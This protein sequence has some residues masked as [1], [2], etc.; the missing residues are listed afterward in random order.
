M[1]YTTADGCPSGVNQ[2][3]IEFL[4]RELGIPRDHTRLVLNYLARAAAE[5]LSE[6]QGTFRLAGIGRLSWKERNGR[7]V[8]QYG[9]GKR[10]VFLVS[11][12]LKARIGLITKKTRSEVH[13]KPNL[14]R[15][16]LFPDYRNAPAYAREYKQE[17]A[18]KRFMSMFPR[19]TTAS[20]LRAIAP[21]YGDVR[22]AVA[23]NTP[24]HYAVGQVWSF[25][26]EDDP[27][28]PNG[29][30]PLAKYVCS[31]SGGDESKWEVSE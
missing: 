20:Y 15:R 16:K 21:T 24:G 23:Q 10:L 17:Q 3:H 18:R 25:W 6:D 31:E 28:Q 14:I 13:R 22:Q 9:P 30:L 4:Y 11:E 29:I 2:I 19:F 27:R 26:L 8:A 5:L 12:T 7:Q 1:R